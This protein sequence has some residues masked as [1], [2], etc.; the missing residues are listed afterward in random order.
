MSRSRLKTGASGNRPLSLRERAGARARR[1]SIVL[2][3]GSLLLAHIAIGQDAAQ[4]P[5]AVKKQD[6]PGKSEPEKKAD[7]PKDGDGEKRLD[8]PAMFRKL[9]SPANFTFDKTPLK[10]VAAQ[11][12]KRQDVVIRLD[13]AAL[14]RANV[15][16]DTPVTATIKNLTLNAALEQILKGLKLRHVAK[17]GQLVITSDVEV[18]DLEKVGKEHVERKAEEARDRADRVAAAER[19]AGMPG[20]PGAAMP[21][22]PAGDLADL[23]KQFTR[24]FRAAARVEINFVEK[25]CQPTSEQL[26]DLEEALEKY[27][28]DIANKYADKHKREV[29]GGRQV[30]GNPFPSD[31]R[32]MVR[33]IVARS[34]KTSLN[35]EQVNHFEGEV[36]ERTADR[37]RAAV[38]HLIARLDRDLNLSADQRDRLTS[39]LSENWNV[40]WEQQFETLLRQPGAQ[41]FP[42]VRQGLI[43]P[44]LTVTQRK[45]WRASLDSNQPN[46]E[47]IF[48]QNGLIG[49]MGG[50][51]NDLGNSDL[52]DDDDEKPAAQPLPGRRTL[53]SGQIPAGQAKDE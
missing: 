9:R 50:A 53:K 2:L 14:K 28:T 26:Q 20:A 24:Q 52:D 29:R 40:T 38:G 15:A 43:A 32:D 10:D 17:N 19:D 21:G 11:I 23:E 51:I 45:I 34:V 37:K 25:V 30:A 12:S 27:R 5:A 22:M 8:G 42:Q 13:D 36:A 7:A 4:R 48:L 16:P 6:E 39:A 31:P 44:I 46:Q 3:L 41:F 35:A 49:A 18:L 1:L 47:L 33:R